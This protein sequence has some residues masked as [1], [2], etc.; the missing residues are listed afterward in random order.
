MSTNAILSQVKLPKNKKVLLRERKRHTDRG[1]SSTPMCCPVRGGGATRE[2]PT[3]GTLHPDLAWG[4]LGWVPPDWP[5]PHPD[6]AGGS[7]LGRFPLTGVTP[8]H[9]DLAGGYTWWAPPGWTWLGSPP[10]APGWGTPPQLDLAGV[11]PAQVW[12]DKVKL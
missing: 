3:Q 8:P 4:Y 9:P 1:I 2:A 7:T 5:T 10:A 11:P 12:T 6:L